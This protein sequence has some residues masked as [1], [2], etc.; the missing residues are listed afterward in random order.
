MAVH[1]P[2]LLKEV[3]DNFTP[4]PGQKYIDC[5]AG[6]GGHSLAIAKLVAP[7]GGVLSINA[8]PQELE[9]F[10]SNIEDAG[11]EGVIEAVHGNYTD[12]EEIADKYGFISPN[13]ILFDLGFS[14]W[15]LERSGRGFTFQKQ[16]PLDMRFN[17]RDENKETAAYIV[18]NASKDHL[19]WI[20][21]EY[22]E[23]G[24]A[25]KIAEAIVEARAKEKIKTTGDLVNIISQA[26]IG[27]GKISPAT[28]TF[29]ALR[30]AV[31]NE[32]ENIKKGLDAAIDITANK[33][34]IA[35]ISFHSLEDRIIK[36]TFKRWDKEG[37]G[38]NITKK[39]IQPQYSETRENPR[40]R[41]AKLR[42]FKKIIK[43]N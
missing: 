42:I 17:P 7:N 40:A 43:N 32:L 13:G 5:T 26:G 9:L 30:I 38:D 25:E 6:E 31:N 36:Q 3:L 21:K 34:K 28:K 37:R 2:V 12:I 22:G 24:R 39:V 15:Q 33:G 29:Q 35:V 18:N 1:I 23:E 19:V 14:S 27:G 20:L 16:E 8:D 10:R 4:A 41:S 11:L